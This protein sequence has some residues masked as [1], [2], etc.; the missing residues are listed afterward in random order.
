[1]YRIKS[2]SVCAY[3]RQELLMYM[4]KGVSVCISKEQEALIYMMKGNVC[5]YKQQ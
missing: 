4:M 2:E 3:K 1:M 5:A